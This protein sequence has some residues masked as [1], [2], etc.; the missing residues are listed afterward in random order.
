MTPKRSH[1]RWRVQ[2]R[3]LRKRE[4]GRKQDRKKKMGEIERNGGSEEGSVK[5]SGR[6]I[7]HAFTLSPSQKDLT[8]KH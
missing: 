3:S 7:S 6:S 2:I 1:E 8:S 5:S 4:R